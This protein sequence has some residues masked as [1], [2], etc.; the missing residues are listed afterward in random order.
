MQKKTYAA[1]RLTVHGDVRKITL[2]HGHSVTDV[3]KGTPCCN[4]ISGS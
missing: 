2:Q 4:D 1:P 3:P